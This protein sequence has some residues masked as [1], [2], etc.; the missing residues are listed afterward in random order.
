MRFFNLKY[1]AHTLLRLMLAVI[2]IGHTLAHAE[3]ISPD[4]INITTPRYKANPV[5]YIDLVYQ[6]RISW[7]GI[8]VA[9]A[10]ISVLPMGNDLP[11]QV[12]VV[13]RAK[14][15]KAIDMFY[16]MR[17]LSEAVFDGKVF[18]PISFFSQQKENRREK[19][20]VIKYQGLG[21]IASEQS[22][23]K[24]D[25]SYLEFD[26]KNATYDPLSGA[27]L[28]KSVEPE[29]GKAIQIDIF[30]GKHRFLISFLYQGK[31]KIKF[32]QTERDAYLVIPTLNRL[33][34]TEHEHRFHHAKLWVSAD[35]RRDIL[36]MESKVWIGTVVAELEQVNGIP[37]TNGENVSVSSS[38]QS[39]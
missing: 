10:T 28:A 30:N 18:E 39:N 19:H 31:E 9:T 22:N 12:K 21:K 35:A 8:P 1:Q 15:A 33:T 13:A 29:I 11:G 17:H 36:K 3:Y 7:Q 5:T 37:V 25:R 4:K 6:Y 24:G 32:G 16:K 2:C 27:F 26:T 20:R 14:T 38:K 34:D 23:Q